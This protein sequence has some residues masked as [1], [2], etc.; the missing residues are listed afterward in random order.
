MFV[1]VLA[2]VMLIVRRLLKLS[3]V[4]IIT[5]RGVK[6]TNARLSFTAKAVANVN[7]S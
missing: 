4:Q 5:G 2:S 3:Y 1:P 6:P 7:P